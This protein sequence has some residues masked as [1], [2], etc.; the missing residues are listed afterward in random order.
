MTLIIL[1]YALFASSFSMGKVLLR[2]TTP[3]FLTGIRMF[4]GGLILLTYQYFY[5]NKHFKFKARHI[6]YYAQIVFFGIY[7]TYIL[8]FWALNYLPSSK[9]CFLY[10][11]SPFLS[12]IFSYFIFSEKMNKQK[13][14]GLLIG[15][16]GLIPMLLSTTPM[17]QV[18]GEFSFLSLPELAVLI[19]V[20]THTYSWIVMR[21]LVKDKSYSPMMVNG[22]SMT[23]GG[24][25]A[26]VTSYF[27]EGVAPITNFVPFATTLA[28]VIL[29]SNIICYNFYGYLL[30]KYT[31]TFL[32]FAGFL[33][34]LFAGLYGWLFLD[35]TI[36]WHFYLSSVIVFIGLYLFYQEELQEVA[37]PNRL[38]L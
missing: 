38:D 31:A 11:L 35:E 8:R 20:A 23:A 15:C 37:Q 13:I 17:E 21:K 4:L 14:A 29:I 28:A 33:G 7:I 32:S 18:I 26:L 1:L 34:P 36:T 16:F 24:F 5:E 10:N 3:I 30:K 25:F 19:S 2:Y 27:T 6:K 9:T 12:A 22:I